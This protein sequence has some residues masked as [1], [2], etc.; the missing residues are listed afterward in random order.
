MESNAADVKPEEAK[1]LTP[2]EAKILRDKE[3]DEY[4]DQMLAA[5]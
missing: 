5:F 2:E 4:F 1:Q 3:E